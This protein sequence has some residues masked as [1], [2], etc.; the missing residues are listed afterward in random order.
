MDCSKCA[1]ERFR[2]GRSSRTGRSAST[3]SLTATGHPFHTDPLFPPFSPLPS[4]LLPLVECVA[5]L[6]VDSRVPCPARLMGAVP[7][8]ER[9]GPDAA[10]R[11]GQT[12]TRRHA[13]NRER[14]H[15]HTQHRPPDDTKDTRYPTTTNHILTDEQRHTKGRAT[16]RCICSRTSVTDPSAPR[17]CS[18]SAIPSRPL[19]SPPL[20]ISRTCAP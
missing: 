11:C 19:S 1:W 13:R 15:R 14:Q 6:F 8:C 7:L 18:H 3:T 10:G 20:V 17:L 2:G 16:S 12:R 9:G 4:L 5:C